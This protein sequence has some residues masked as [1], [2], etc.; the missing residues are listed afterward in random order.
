MAIWNDDEILTK[1]EFDYIQQEV[2]TIKV[3][4][5]VGRIPHKISSKFSGFTADQ[6]MN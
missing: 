6:W 1:P 4:A 2:D 3:P 5:G